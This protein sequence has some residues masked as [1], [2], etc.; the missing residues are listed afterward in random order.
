V[1]ESDKLKRTF[2]EGVTVNYLCTW[3]G[4]YL[5][6]G[7]APPEFAKSHVDPT[8]YMRWWQSL[9]HT[10]KQFVERLLGAQIRI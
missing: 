2:T 10:D 7:E 6:L 9:N 1:L 5:A 4:P 3:K 8:G